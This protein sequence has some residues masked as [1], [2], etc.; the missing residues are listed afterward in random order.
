LSPEL[1]KLEHV[2]PRTLWDHEARHFTPWLAANLGLL[3]EALGLDLALLQ[4]EVSVGSFNADI[5]ARDIGRDRQ[6][7]GATK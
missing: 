6:V 5:M 3:A 7:L 1:G 4:T 2:E